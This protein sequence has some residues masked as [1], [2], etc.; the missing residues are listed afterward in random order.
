MRT[1]PFWIT[2]ALATTILSLS[3]FAR[4]AGDGQ[5]HALFTRAA[6]VERHVGGLG[7]V[8]TDV[9][10]T[11]RMVLGD[12]RP[13][14]DGPYNVIG[15]TVVHHA[16]TQEVREHFYN[17]PS[18]I[19]PD[20]DHTPGDIPLEDVYAAKTIYFLKKAVLAES[21]IEGGDGVVS[22]LG[23]GEI[24]FSIAKNE[25]A[26]VLGYFRD[27]LAVI[28]MN[29]KGPERMEMLIDINSLDTAVPGRNNRI[30]NLFFRSM[31][32]DLGDAVVVFDQFDLGKR[33][34]KSWREGKT[35][36]IRASGSIVLNGVARDISATLDVTPRNRGWMVET[37]EP[38]ALL[39]SDFQF[40]NRIYDLMK[41]CNHKSV[42]NTVGVRVQLYFK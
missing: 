34:F 31:E 24:S 15:R 42:G 39:I 12:T 3:G 11:A 8:S 6:A 7:N 5:P 40:G 1:Y 27:Y 37:Q 36:S 28:S 22:T 38:I 17:D 35:Y 10:G 33:S 23:V 20:P 25:S 41:S 19:H 2:V 14:V 18:N 4:Q 32:S 29:K 9:A 30:L 26:E 21:L 13:T 16:G